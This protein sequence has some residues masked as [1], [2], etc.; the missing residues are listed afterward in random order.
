MHN[1]KK[2]YD[3]PQWTKYEKADFLLKH[4]NDFTSSNVTTY[5]KS[6]EKKTYCYMITFTLKPE[7]KPEQYDFIENYIEKQF[8]ERP[9]L[10]VKEAHVTREFHKSGVPHWHVSVQTHKPLKNDRF[11]YYNKMYGKTDFS[12]SKA[13]NIHESLNY[14]SKSETPK[15][16]ASSDILTQEEAQ[17]GTNDNSCP[18][19]LQFE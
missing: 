17:M 19:L 1:I 13:Q 14:I 12:K 7:I 3:N 18:T 11:N 6:L 16:L 10:Q 15:D 9:C 2:F 4:L 5:L 8:K